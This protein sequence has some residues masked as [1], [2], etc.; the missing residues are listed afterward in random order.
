MNVII[1]GSG[2]CVST[3]ERISLCKNGMPSLKIL[4][5]EQQHVEILRISWRTLA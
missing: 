2:G 1:I 5:D 4:A 3:P